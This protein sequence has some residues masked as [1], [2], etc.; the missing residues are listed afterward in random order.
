MVDVTRLQSVPTA[1]QLFDFAKGFAGQIPSNTRVALVVR[2]EQVRQAN[3]VEKITRKDGVFLTYF[4]DPDKAA[5]WVKQ[6]SAPS[7]RKLGPVG[8]E[9]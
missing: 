5:L 7:R 9:N 2:P 4:L 6:T 3:L 1:L 8:K